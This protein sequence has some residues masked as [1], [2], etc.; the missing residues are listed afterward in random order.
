MLVWYDVA[1]S[2]ISFKSNGYVLAGNMFAASKPG[3]IAFLFIQG[4]QGHQNVEAAQALA[5]LGFTSITYDMRGNRESEGNLAEFSRADFIEDATVAYDYLKQRVGDDVAIG[6]IGS[7]FGSY[8]AVLLS[9]KRD[10]CCLS[11]RVPASYPDEGFNDPS[12]ARAEPDSVMEWRKS[13]LDYTQNHAF[14]ALHDF[15]GKVQII[16]AGA[17]EIVPSQ[18]PKNYADAA[19]DKSQMTYEVMANAPHRLITEELQAD[20]VERLTKWLKTLVWN[21][22]PVPVT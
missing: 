10:V 2:R 7:S 19:P 12:L 1:M 14:K 22:Q 8:T 13:K 20:Y 11:L 5:D 4:W 3:K 17:D 18:T 6:A 15:K 9:K 16:E 21:M